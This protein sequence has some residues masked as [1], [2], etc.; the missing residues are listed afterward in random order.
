MTRWTTHSLRARLAFDF[1]LLA[2]AMVIGGVAV[3]YHA[4]REHCIRDVDE[5]L[6]L[7]LQSLRRTVVMGETGPRVTLPPETMI[8]SAPDDGELLWYLVRRMDGTELSRSSILVPM[9]DLPMLPGTDAIPIIQDLVLEDGHPLRVAGQ[10][11]TPP[12]ESGVTAAPAGAGNV[13]L[14]VAVSRR[15]L[16]DYLKQVRWILGIGGACSL[17]VLTALAAWMV[18]RALGPIGAL[19]REISRFPVGSPSRFSTPQRAVELRPVVERLN[20]LM[21]RV[22]RTLARERGFAMGAA[23]ELR[24]PLAGLRARLELALSRPRSAE[25]YRAELSEALH[26]EQGLESMVSHLLLLARLG[27]EGSGSFLLKPLAVSQFLRASWGE[28]FD[29]AEQRRLRVAIR[30]PESSPELITSEDLMSLLI[31]NLLDNAVS[32]T[33]E[34]GRI[35][36]EATPTA[37]AWEISVTNTN[38]G[39][40]EA[41]LPRLAEPFWRARREESSHDGRHAGL[42]LALCHR[43]AAELGATLAHTLTNDGRVRAT[44]VHPLR[45]SRRQDPSSEH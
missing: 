29:R 12:L 45:P 9:P 28:F 21:D 43:I 13:H 3:L 14:A 19:S 41:D 37:E 23:H 39:L 22:G 6:E 18:H 38:P 33:P 1:A 30:V 2:L 4:Y 25:E 31:R 17:V 27:Q 44:L 36:I 24:T 11:I 40:L 16:L 10:V 42:G 20:N 15:P 7:V 34:E 8:S 35:T 32:Y 5:K 26:I